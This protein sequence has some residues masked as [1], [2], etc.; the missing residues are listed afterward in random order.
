MW[1]GRCFIKRRGSV[2]IYLLTTTKYAYRDEDDTIIYDRKRVRE[3]LG[4]TSRQER[5]YLRSLRR[6][7]YLKEIIKFDNGRVRIFYTYTPKA[8]EFFRK[9]RD[10]LNRVLEDVKVEVRNL[11]G[12]RL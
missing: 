6:R 10:S 3:E 1:R 2:I 8:L 11:G 12:V 7:N 4:I 9:L 5:Y